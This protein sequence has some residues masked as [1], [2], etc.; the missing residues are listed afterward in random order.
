MRL[1]V[2]L[3]F[4]QTLGQVDLW[5]DVPHDEASGHVDLWSD[6]PPDEASDQVDI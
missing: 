1:R 3:T 6:V 5:S 4:G 2:R